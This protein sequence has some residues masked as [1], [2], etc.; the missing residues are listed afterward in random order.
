MASKPIRVT[1][2]S[3]LFPHEGEPTLGVFV[4]N[5]L[6]KLLEYENIEVTVIAPVPWFPFKSRF[7]GAYGRA[8]RAAKFEKRHGVSIYHPRY[9]VIPKFGMRLTP[10]FMYRAALKCFRT[11]TAKGEDFHLIDAHY[12]YPD[13]VVAAQLGAVLNRPVVMTARGSD[14]T[15]IGL[16]QGPRQDICAALGKVAHTITVSENLRRDLISMGGRAAKITTLRNGVDLD[17]FREQNRQAVRKRWGGDQI[18]LFAG[19]LIPRKRV[20]LVLDVTSR[21]PGLHTV[22]VGDGPLR[23]SLEGQMRKLKIADRVSFIGQISPAQMPEIY[24]GADILLLPSDREGWAN[25]LLEAMA[26]GTP[27]VTRAIGGA[28]ELMTDKAAG[29]LVDSADA[30]AL[31]NAVRALLADLPNRDDTRAFA[32]RFDWRETS[33]GQKK[34]FEK[35]IA[36]YGSPNSF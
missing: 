23:S 22:I 4:E 3:S 28:P 36:D 30:E 17:I 21:I 10:R 26:C 12:L 6:R 2:F 24:S 18:L 5:R 31:A 34:I 33:H 32:E 25:V 20:D 13:G 7:F 14:V 27:V 9:L 1:L 35:A 29:I 19:W 16:L 11:L 8:A 15:Q